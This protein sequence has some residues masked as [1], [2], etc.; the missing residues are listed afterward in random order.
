[1]NILGE[2]VIK[3][4]IIIVTYSIHFY[5]GKQF[6]ADNMYSVWKYR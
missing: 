5:R 4:V 3:N 1:M 6:D 2:G